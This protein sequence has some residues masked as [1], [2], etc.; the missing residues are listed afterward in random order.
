MGEKTDNFKLEDSFVIMFGTIIGYLLLTWYLDNV[1]PS[2]YGVPKHPLFCFY[3]SE[4]L[5]NKLHASAQRDDMRVR[6]LL[7]PRVGWGGLI[8][9]GAYFVV[10]RFV[11]LRSDGRRAV[12][13]GSWLE[14]RA[15]FAPCCTLRRLLE[16]C[17][18][19]EEV[20]VRRRKPELT[21]ASQWWCGRLRV[22][23]CQPP[24]RAP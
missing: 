5:S 20:Q 6:R 21:P 16:V 4:W 1:W 8:G 7:H 9:D 17:V 22:V 10:R 15:V 11:L 3:P 23:R 12:T 14:V 18:L 13:R 2:E 19:Q 24:H